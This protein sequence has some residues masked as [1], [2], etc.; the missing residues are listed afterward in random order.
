MNFLEKNYFSFCILPLVLWISLIFVTSPGYAKEV[1]TGDALRSIVLQLPWLHQFQFAGYYMAVEKD[2]YKN[3][4]FKVDIRQGKPGLSSIEEVILGRSNYGVA[5]SEL[6]LHR[7]HGKPV[8]ALA[9]IFQHS[10]IC[11]LIKAESGINNPQDLIDRKIM[12]LEGDDAA[13][14]IAM[15]KNEGVSIDQIHI[16]PSSFNIND[17][18]EG[19]IDA[20]DAYITNEPYFMQKEGFP[21][22]IIQPITY[23]IDFYGDSLFTSEK[24]CK[25]HADQVK[26]FRKASLLGWEYA[27]ANPEETIDLIIKKYNVQKTREHLKYE[28]EVTRKLIVPKLVEIGH[29]NPGRWRHMAD[30]YVELNMV[31]PDYSLEGFIYDPNS[32]PNNRWIKWVLFVAGIILFI[33]FVC[34]IALILFNKRLRFI[35]NERTEELSLK[36]KELVHEINERM[37]AQKKARD[38]FDIV[39][40]S[41]IMAFIW[42][43]EEGWPIEFV[44]NNVKTILGYD[45]NDLMSGKIPY[46]KIIYPDDINRVSIEVARSSEQKNI[47]NFVH[48][49]Y[50]I[51]KKD[52][53]VIWV[54]NQT[55]IRRDDH[56]EI[57]HYQ[58]IIEDISE[59]KQAEDAL[60]ESEER[61][62]AIVEDTPVL[63]C[64]FLVEGEITFVNDAYC[65]Y[66]KKSYDQLIGKTFLSLIPKPER[67]I[68]INNISSLS[69]DSPTQTHE[70][71]VILPDG[72]IRWQRWT[73]RA[74]FDDKGNAVTYQSVG[75][76][77]TVRKQMEARLQEAQKMEAVG[78][79]AGGIAHDFNNMLGV[80]TG[81]VS[82]ALSQLNQGEEMFEV[83][84]DVQ[85]GA[86]QAQKLTQQLLTFAKG[87]APVRKATNIQHVIKES[88]LFVI[89]G[90]LSK[91]SFEMP[92]DIW[93]SEVDEGQINQ[94]I[95]NLVINANQA[96]PDGGLVQIRVKNTIIEPKSIVPLAPG[97]YIKVEIED[98][99][100]GISKKHL[101]KIFDPYF[102]T[103]QK[104]SGLGLA[105]A[106]SIIKR[107]DG[108]IAVY[109]EVEKGTVFNIYLPA[110]TKEIGKVEDK[111]E[112]KHTGQ[113]KILVMD[114][115]ESILKMAGRMLNNM[116]YDTAL[117]IDGHQA[118]EMYREAYQAQNPFDLVILDL[119]IPGGM[120]GTKTIIE[121]LKFDANV[122]AVVSSGYS[123][124]PIMANYA[125]YG[126]CGV[127]PKPYTKIQLAEVLNKIFEEN[128]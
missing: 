102:S 121:L 104:G 107:H 64:R 36:N 24:E 35:V 90:T 114:D 73:N 41:P 87:G 48:E 95:S 25:D 4:G 54:N 75:E 82:Y 86:K 108:H 99:G 112:S 92:D 72:E 34:A 96:M 1:K 38:A 63:I 55:Q 79:L 124:D 46:L 13:E 32:I 89:R 59:R 123:N 103:K 85:G 77:I 105:T 61:Y 30:T 62:R 49:P 98:Q 83:L 71:R 106:Y 57:T 26:L 43:N 111:K 50:R 67:E 8:V 97:R 68:V 122:K 69:I 53:C 128:D 23:G 94:V 84:S 11:L 119:T 44:S 27:L 80:I 39:N 31:E 125:D 93:I 19:K 120:G 18:I 113:G 116:G 10:A 5:K 100:V 56:G 81:N 20:F 2:Y 52:G 126:F 40:N 91:C 22:T 7:L 66:F 118:I 109:S 45:V 78:A 65:K 60:S 28:A 76:D 6:L 47:E 17:L 12:L 88:A 37:H 74:L 15:F 33:S 115:Q 117:A 58:G 3:A 51:L 70:H 42:R 14:Y 127:V 29:M 101:S 21:S 9:T 16:I 110:S